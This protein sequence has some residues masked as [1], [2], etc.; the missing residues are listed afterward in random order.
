MKSYI[1]CK[2]LLPIIKNLF[3]RNSYLRPIGFFIFDS[4]QAQ[5]NSAVM[6]PEGG[7]RGRAV[8]AVLPQQPGE[9]GSAHPEN[10]QLAR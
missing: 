6:S 2:C 4:D 8:C 3:S 9:P 1:L 7:T 5:V 10:W